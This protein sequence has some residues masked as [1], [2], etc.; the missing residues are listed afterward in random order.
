MERPPPVDYRS[1]RESK[2]D[3]A[4]YVRALDERTRA[5]ETIEQ[6]IVERLQPLADGRFLEVGCGTGD[7]ARAMAQLVGPGGAVVAVD[8][9]PHMIAE[10]RRRAEGMD[11]PIEFRL[12]DAAQLDLP[13]ACFDGCRTERVLLHVPDPRAVIAEMVRVTRPGGRVVCCEPDLGTLIVDAPD[14]ATTRTVLALV[15][16]R[17]QQPWIGRQLS[18]LFKAAGL[19]DVTT[20]LLGGVLAELGYT[21]R[22]FAL[23][24][25]AEGAAEAG[26]VAADAAAAWVRGL[27]EAEA[28]GRF[29][30]AITT[31]LVSGR[32]R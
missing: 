30:G 1:W 3:Q 23:R 11:L 10:A 8:N 19:V 22:A 26:L 4:E 25:T 16:E 2:I 13:D 27:D 21:D 15:A 31:F 6:R 24:G 20:V 12:G 14:R 7:D 32:K 18:G 29:F 17:H 5:L 9:N 28:A